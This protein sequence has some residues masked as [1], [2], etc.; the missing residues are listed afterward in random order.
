MSFFR[1]GE[2]LDTQSKLYAAKALQKSTK[3]GALYKGL[4]K[5][6]IKIPYLCKLITLNVMITIKYYRIFL[7]L[8]RNKKKSGL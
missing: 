7:H 2:F 3:V 8:F 1:M 4:K 6:K 5:V